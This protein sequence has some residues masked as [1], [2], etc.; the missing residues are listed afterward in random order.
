MF[1]VMVLLAGID[2]AGRPRRCR[3]AKWRE[4]S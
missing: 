2:E 3:T 4:A 1:M